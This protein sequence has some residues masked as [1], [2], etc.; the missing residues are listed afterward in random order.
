MKM[1]FRDDMALKIISVLIAIGLWFYVVQV[2][3][4]DIERTVKGIPVVFSQKDSL[5]KKGLSLLNDKEHT[6]DIKIRGKRKYVMDAS[7]ENITVLADVSGIS[8]TGSHTL[9]TNIVLPYANLEITNQSPSALNIT[10]D[11]LVAVKKDII[12]RTTGTPKDG[13]A[14]GKITVAPKTVTLKGPKTILDGVSSVVAELDIKDKSS[15]IETIL[16]IKIYGSNEREIKS[17]YI[18]TDISETEVRCEILKTK[19]VDIQ[20]IIDGAGLLEHS[21]YRLDAASLKQVKVAGSEEQIDALVQIRTKRISPNS[22][23]E[24]GEVT[25]ELELP[26]GIRSLEGDSFT[27]RL[28]R[29]GNSQ[30]QHPQQPPQN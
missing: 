24:N 23:K 25:V 11:K 22:I 12:V 30:M 18:S 9:Y 17:A 8:E 15:D 5:E 26:P 6:I 29:Q 2:Q 20:P 16:P 27:L 10:V 19:L 3:S 14:A 7:A 4:P 1:N 13:F 28:V 21:E